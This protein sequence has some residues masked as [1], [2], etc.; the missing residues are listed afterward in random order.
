MNV[1]TVVC[2]TAPG[3]YRREERFSAYALLDGVLTSWDCSHL[4]HSDRAAQKC[5]DQLQRH[6]TAFLCGATVTRLPVG[7]H[8]R[9]PDLYEVK[10]EYNALERA[11]TGCTGRS[12]RFVMPY[13]GVAPYEG[14][15]GPI[16]DQMAEHF[17]AHPDAYND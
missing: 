11:Q 9:N 17:A 16:R 10:A 14:F 15:I 3:S 6:V 13:S 4:H 12:R 7:P 1:T 8:N 2:R 5:L